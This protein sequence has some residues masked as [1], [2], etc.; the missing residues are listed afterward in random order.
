M[1]KKRKRNL[2]QEFYI[3]ADEE[4]LIADKMQEA[5]IKNKSAYLRKM[6]LDGYIIRQ[7][8]QTLKGV[9]YEL[10]RTGNNLNQMTKIANTYGDINY[11]EL[12]VI[13]GDIKKIW[14]LLSSKV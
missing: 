10:N 2:K 7:D 6:A 11:S 9:V 1:I 14:R 8:Y 13:E 12:K 5:G 3:S 4:Q